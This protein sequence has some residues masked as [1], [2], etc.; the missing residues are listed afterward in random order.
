MNNH[1]YKIIAVAVLLLEFIIS[2]SLFA[3]IRNLFLENNINFNSS[4]LVL[5]VLLL[6]LSITLFVIIYRNP[7]QVKEQIQENSFNDIKDLT[8]NETQDKNTESINIKEYIQRIIPKEKSKD[9]EKYTERILSNIAKEFDVVQ[10]LFFIKERTSDI[11]KNISKYAYLGEQEPQ[12]F[13]LGET[14]SGQVAKNKT[15]LHLKDIPENYVTILSG[16]GTSS[17]NN[18]LIIPVVHN[19]VTIGIIE[20]ALFKEISNQ[21]DTLFKELSNVLGAKLNEN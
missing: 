4:I 8:K 1:R 20:L 16:L 11:F 2:F 21:Y 15:M 13:K 6:L 17:P 3:K 7:D 19:H 12:N 18:L 9:I 10:G 5:I 14:L